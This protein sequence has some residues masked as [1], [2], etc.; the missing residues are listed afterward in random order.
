MK[1]RKKE[2]PP[3]IGGTKFIAGDLVISRGSFAEERK[4]T[5]SDGAKTEAKGLIDANKEEEPDLMI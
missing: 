5:P 3:V 2:E 4:V 1:E